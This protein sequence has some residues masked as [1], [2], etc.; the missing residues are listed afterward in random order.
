VKR[1][2]KGYL[3]IATAGVLWGTI[4]IH[5]KTL[6]NY[7]ISVQTIVLWKMI[8]AILLIFPFIFFTNRKILKV[9]LRGLIYFSIIGIFI[10]F[11]SPLFYYITIEKTTIATAV[12]LVYTSPIFIAIMAKIFYKEKFSP[13]KIIALLLCIGGVF[14][15]ASG[16]SL[17][18]L[19]LNFPGVLTGLGS[20]FTFA[21]LPII[22]KA[23]I[24]D[25]HQFTIILY[26]ILFSLLFYL[27]FS[28]PLAIFQITFNLNIWLLLF[29]IGVTSTTI[30][31]GLYVIGLSYDIETSR[32]GIISTLELVVSVILSYL[33]F[34]EAL[35][36]WK[37]I[38]IIM[39]TFSIIIVQTDKLLFFKKEK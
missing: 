14:F 19:N 11:F 22:S 17:K 29:S 1:Q 23:I 9:D 26:S 34:K 3:M 2:T 25:Y 10:H 8:F 12:T 21:L 32:V 37:L 27:P 35:W 7:H 28:N 33:I 39:V 13:L 6:F 16:G 5:V 30:A 15:T 18:T 4:G 31:Y 36:G 20:G 38:G 24:N